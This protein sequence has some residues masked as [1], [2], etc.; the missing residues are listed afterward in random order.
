[1]A[2]PLGRAAPDGAAASAATRAP[3]HTRSS[4]CATAGRA[5]THAGRATV[6]SHTTHRKL[7]ALLLWELSAARGA[8]PPPCRIDPQPAG[9][10]L[11]G[12]SCSPGHAARFVR[13]CAIRNEPANGMVHYATTRHDCRLCNL[14]TPTPAGVCLRHYFGKKNLVQ[15][16]AK[17][18]SAGWQT[19]WG[20]KYFRARPSH[21]E[22]CCGKPFPW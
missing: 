11:R 6:P 8:P 15:M 19:I 16:A 14:W 20:D 9:H 12:A 10:W 5:V 13:I 21:G 4:E 18:C 1:M 3:S 2:A 17:S 7:L 22:P